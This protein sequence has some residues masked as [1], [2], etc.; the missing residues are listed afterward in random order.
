MLRCARLDRHGVVTIPKRRSSGRAG[1]S[2]ITIGT[3]RAVADLA[4]GLLIATVEVP[5]AA[6]RVFE[7]L[8]SDE[9][10]RW[11][12]RPGVFD[13]REWTAD[14]RPGGRWRATGVGGG[15]P[16]ALEGEFIEVDSPHRLL[17]T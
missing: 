2:R 16:Y 3:A 6:E 10:C 11:W 14:V 9:V 1:C 7:A 15:R 12:V 13:T 4:E 8:A 5:A 17:H